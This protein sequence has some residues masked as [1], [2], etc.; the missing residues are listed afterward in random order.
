MA[1]PAEIDVAHVA[2]LARLNLT[3][4][5]TKLFQTQLGRVL[6]YAEKLRELDTSHVEAAAHAVPIFN[7]FREDEPRAGFTAKEALSNAPRKANG[8][9]IV[10]KVVE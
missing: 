1:E 9:F 5:E 3:E 8:L 10:T 2:T 6:E 4:K 7:I